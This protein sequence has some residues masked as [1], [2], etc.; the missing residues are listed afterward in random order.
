MLYPIHLMVFSNGFQSRVE[1]CDQAILFGGGCI[2][3]IE[4]IFSALFNSVSKG[5]SRR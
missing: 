2:F 5:V 4:G 1:P 3:I